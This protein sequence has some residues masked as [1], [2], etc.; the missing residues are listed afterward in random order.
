MNDQLNTSLSDLS[1]KL[2]GWIDALILN[3]P[4]IVL[5]IVLFALAYFISQKLHGLVHK[6]IKSRI[7][8]HSIRNLIANIIS[9][10]ILALGLFLALTVLNLD[11]AL[12]SILAGAGVAGLAVGL[13][14]QG[15]I[16]NTFSGIFLSVKDIMNIGDYIETNGFTGV[17][18]NITL[19]YIKL[20]ESD[21]NIVIIPNNLVVENPFKNFGLTRQVKVSLECGVSYDSDLKSVKNVACRAIKQEFDQADEDLHFYYTEFAGSSINFQIRFAVDA[22]KN[23][24]ALQAKSKAIMAIKRAF[25]KYEIDIPYP[26]RTLNMP[27]KPSSTI[28][29]SLA[30]MSSNAD[31]LIR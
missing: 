29:A 12:T 19:R 23:L 18:E 15:T 21:N 2:I 24:T 5:A 9:V 17:V 16:A 20:K 27:D 25:D 7:R 11:K 6:M 30:S 13:A 3:L 26:I 28:E 22:K 10:A 14:L 1:E 31:S 8:Q 4:N